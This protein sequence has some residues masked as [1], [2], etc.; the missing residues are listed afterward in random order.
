[1]SPPVKSPPEN[2]TPEVPVATLAKNAP[3]ITAVPVIVKDEGEAE[4]LMTDGFAVVAAPK[5][6]A[7]RLPE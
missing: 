2:R 4:L 3:A 7:L 1:L 5:V 6:T